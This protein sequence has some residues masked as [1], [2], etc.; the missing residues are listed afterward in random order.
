MDELI[1]QA[2]TIVDVI[3]RQNWKNGGCLSI[4]TD[5]A[6]AVVEQLVRTAYSAGKVDGVKECGERIIRLARIELWGA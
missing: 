1:E 5:E 2:K 3:R 6:V 4:D